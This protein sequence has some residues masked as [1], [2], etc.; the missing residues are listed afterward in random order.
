MIYYSNCKIN[1]GLNIVEKYSDGYH[2]LSTIFFPVKGL[3]D[4][5]EIV[6]AENKS[7]FSSSGID[8]NC[9]DEMNLCMRAYN[10]LKTHYDIP[11]VKIHLHKNIPFGAGLG[12]GSA[13]AA[14]VLMALNSL[15]ELN[16]SKQ[17]LII[18]SSQLGSD[19]AFFIENRPML[20]E[21][22]GEILSDVDLS[23]NGYYLSILKPEC[24]VPTSVAYSMIT[25]KKP[26]FDLRNIAQKEVGEWRGI[27]V[28]DFEQPIFLK[29][30]ML[31]EIKEALYSKGA[32]YVAM[33]GSGSAI[34]AISKSS[35]DLSIFE[36]CN[37][38]FS[39]KIEL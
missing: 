24:S 25:P 3:C 5:I 2:G 13:N 9:P 1:I 34:F 17:Q 32:E 22:R 39:E 12:G 19:V 4:A 38:S 30:P 14:C 28:N 35:I 36:S 21:G 27:V 18:F 20:G 31:D 26:S 37:F 10:L 15:F 29:Y 33:S 23:L 11:F 6:E 8:I 16:I 7:Q